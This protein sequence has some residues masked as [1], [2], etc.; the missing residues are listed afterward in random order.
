LTP[1]EFGHVFN[2]H[3]LTHYP[4]VK[5]W[6]A[7]LPQETRSAWAALFEAQM[8]CDLVA[9]I[10][11]T[12]SGRQPPIAAYDRD[13]TA[14]ILLQRT[15]A[16]RDVRLAKDRNRNQHDE[17]RR[18][19]KLAAQRG[20]TLADGMAETLN[21]AGLGPALREINA[22]VDAGEDRDAVTHEI[23]VQVRNDER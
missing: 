15:R 3:Y 12:V 17:W 14:T 5:A 13:R 6:C 9:A 11:D 8:S 4:D 21:K 23:A 18:D 10:Q 20:G 22:R 2:S 7:Q 16:I 19:K 1:A